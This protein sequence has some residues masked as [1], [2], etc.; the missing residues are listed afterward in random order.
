MDPA[1]TR[2]YYSCAQNIRDAP[3]IDMRSALRARGVSPAGGAALRLRRGTRSR[4]TSRP[5]R[6][7]GDAE[8]GSTSAWAHARADYDD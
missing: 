1:R 6:K 5:E 3:A 2:V 8:K 4:A 7:R